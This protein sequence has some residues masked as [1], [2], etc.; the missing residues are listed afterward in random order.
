[1]PRSH[2][3]ST[4]ETLSCLGRRKQGHA[5]NQASA[6]FILRGGLD[7]G[8]LV[9]AVALLPA[10]AP[11]LGCAVADQDGALLLRPGVHALLETR[12]V[13]L[14][15]SDDPRAQAA[16]LVAEEADRAFGVRD[17]MLV[18]STLVALAPDEHWWLLSCHVLVAEARG[19]ESL[20]ALAG[21]LYQALGQP[22]GAGR[23]AALAPDT[24][25]WEA[26]LDYLESPACAAGQA[27][28]SAAAADHAGLNLPRGP[29]ADPARAHTAEQALPRGW[30]ARYTALA[31]A[32]GMDEDS[33]LAALM[34]VFLHRYSGSET[35]SVG[36]AQARGRLCL[37]GAWAG[38][39]YDNVP[40]AAEVRGDEAFAALADRVAAAVRRGR[41]HRLHP[42]DRLIDV[43]DS[44]K[45]HESRLFDLAVY[46]ERAADAG[47][48]L[49][50][51]RRHP[52]PYRG[53]FVPRLGLVADDAGGL[54]LRLEWQEP[55]LDAA[56]APELLD[57]LATLLGA[58]LDSAGAAAVEDLEMVS[59]AQ[60]KYLL[61][62]LAGVA[63]DGIPHCCVHQMIERQVALTPQATA[64]VYEDEA[65]SYA[66]LDRR[67]DVLAQRLRARGVGPDVMV[68]VFVERSVA[69][70][71]TVL[72]ILKAG[73][74]FVPLDTDF[75]EAR[76][77]YIIG[78]ADL[79]TIVTQE[80][81]APRLPGPARA[82]ALA[83]E[84]VDWQA[85]AERGPGCGP[86]HLAYVIYTS[87]STGNPKGVLVEHAG[88]INLAYAISAELRVEADSRVLQFAS[89]TFDAS[90]AE[91]FITFVRGATL[92][93]A[94][95]QQ[96]LA[97]DL[98][99][100]L[101][102]RHGLSHAILPPVLL[103]YLSREKFG[104]VRQLQVVGESTPLETARTWAAGRTLS[105][106]YGPTENTVHTSQSLF[107]GS[108]MNIGRPI[109]NV[110]AYVLDHKA[111]LVAPGAV[112]ELCIGGAGVTRGYLNQPGLTAQKFIPDP[113]GGQGRLYRSGD[114]V[115][116]L[117]DGNLDFIGR[118]D[119]QVKIRGLRVELEE[120]EAHLER[121]E[122]VDRAV[123][124]VRET[125]AAN[126]D[127]T[128]K[129][130]A[131]YLVLAR[132]GLGEAAIRKSLAASVPQFMVPA[133]IV[134]L[135][136][137]PL[138]HSRKIDKKALKALPLE[139][140]TD[141]R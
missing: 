139:R 69:M 133:H 92:Y 95:H 131:A 112:G 45:E 54:L 81:L 75:P 3:L 52:L 77:A 15:G 21:R 60:R 90:I 13:S 119:Q 37:D 12:L 102:A 50:P 18:R 135:E 103:K 51:V 11:Q 99:S 134:I 25:S 67:A 20:Y 114:L 19:C 130:L 108:A 8:R 53:E 107:D 32:L 100:D 88:V 79:S 84:T 106:G 62:P 136:R 115:R 7:P 91:M 70:V 47:Y 138:T 76:L 129:C 43:A 132:S 48:G 16:R 34:L 46:Y 123:V 59:P 10:L 72:A 141:G 58:L 104:S 29:A 4:F 57:S 39:A 49:G 41:Q 55:D 113:C 30:A 126:G 44:R 97:P 73:G 64:V 24:A 96:R 74:A 65:L 127:S 98:L 94:S 2:P 9:R 128:E 93:V 68:G 89:L 40:L 83:L 137:F 6:C 35:V 116:W 118:R 14:A 105:N 82:H 36:L 66:E 61:G 22:G 87:G 28:W 78:D 121:I 124:L 71:V 110:R 1:M 117:P 42:Q 26:R 17:Q 38:I 31:A 27:Y 122:G 111:R 85:P 109:H 101:V 63:R 120:V 80:H 33:M 125:A 86:S 5:A 23:L 140:N 56:L